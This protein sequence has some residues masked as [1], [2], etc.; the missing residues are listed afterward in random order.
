MK[1]STTKSFV[2]TIFCMC[3]T[4]LQAQTMK[5]ID[6]NVYKT[7]KIGTQTW[8]AENLNVTKY[9]DGTA[10]PLV[11]DSATWVNLT[12]PGMCWYNNDKAKYTANKY[13]A[14]YNW[15]TVK[16]GKISPKGWHVPTDAD[17]NI[18]IDYLKANGYSCDA[19]THGNKLSKSI[20]SATNDWTVSK[21]EG[22]PGNDVSKNNK[23]GFSALPV[24]SRSSYG[25]FHILGDGSAWW[26]STEDEESK[27]WNR[28]L[29][30]NNIDLNTYPGDKKIG[31]S[32][33]LIKD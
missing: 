11:T 29:G 28:D 14:F 21:K 1:I 17:W 2:A 15:F 19:A 24:G 26:S 9:N 22:A 6:G 4:S 32:I 16:S 13:G 18:L 30:Y 8:M 5:D 23:S 25:V 20:A 31:L 7:V 33:R 10:I 12:T 3:L 27:A